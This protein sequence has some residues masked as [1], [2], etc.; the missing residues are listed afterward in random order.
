M[1]TCEDS[2]LTSSQG[3]TGSMAAY[4]TISP[5]GCLTRAQQLLHIG[6]YDLAR[7]PHAGTPA[8]RQERAHR[9]ELL[10]EEPR[11]RALAQ[12]PAFKTCTGEVS[13]QN[14]WL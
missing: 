6:K 5:E 7:T 12:T 9:A 8:G 11:V 14:T 2:E 13:P 3:H 1:A 10:P 4:G